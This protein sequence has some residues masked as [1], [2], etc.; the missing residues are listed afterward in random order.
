M[1]A[2][3]QMWSSTLIRIRSSGLI[4]GSLV[5]SSDVRK[6]RSCRSGRSLPLALVPV[7]SGCASRTLPH[8]D[9]RDGRHPH[10][11]GRRAHLRARGVGR[12]R[13]LGCGGDQDRAR[14][15][16]RRG[17][18]AR[19]DRHRRVQRQGRGAHG[20]RQP[21]QEE[22]RPR[23]HQRRG[24]RHPLP[25]RRDLRRLPHQQD[26][27][28]PRAAADR[29]RRHPG[30]QPEHRLRARHRL[31]Q[32]RPRRR[33]RRL[34]LARVLGPFRRRAL[35]HAVR[36]AA[37]GQPARARVRRLDRRHD[38]RR[39][40]LRRAPPP[41]AH[42]RGDRGRRLAAVHRRCGRWA[43][44][45]RCRRTSGM[46]VAGAARRPARGAV[47][48][49]H[50]LLRDVRRP[51]H[52]VL[53]AAGL[54]L[55]ARGLRALRTAMDLIGD[56]RFDTAREAHG[57]RGGRRRDRSRGEIKKY[58]LEEIKQKLAGMRASGRSCRTRSR[59]PTTR[60]S[61]PTATC[62]E[63]EY[64]GYPY[65]LVATPVQFDEEPS[66]PGKSPDFNEHGDEILTEHARPRLGHHRSTSR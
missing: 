64:D 48:P 14:H 65:K 57:E 24:P 25:A 49:A 58:T 54:P 1:S 61:S 11:R 9:E 42:R 26:G 3:S 36:P 37:A 43:A 20:A 52:H 5:P 19:L 31:R 44:P 2:G 51:V 28:R 8:H 4:I 63:L 41:R 66:V 29:G 7:T 47:Q 34:R 17:P 39:R 23:P 30:P 62:Q 59:S 13:R 45:S 55:L 46:A 15:P 10:P 40:H 56:P 60:R 6:A 38:H 27:G 12:P 22:P 32:P 21:G 53:D 50:R 35:G 18:R 16:R 33:R